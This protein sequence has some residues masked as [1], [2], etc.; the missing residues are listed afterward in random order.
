MFSVTIALFLMI[1]TKATLQTYA[2]C[3]TVGT[4][5]QSVFFSEAERKSDHEAHLI[6]T[7]C[8]ETR[9]VYVRKTYESIAR[10]FIFT[11]RNPAYKRLSKKTGNN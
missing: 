6:R 2:N 10:E 11:P 4:E 7:H 8:Q 9:L 5:R 1:Y 3:S